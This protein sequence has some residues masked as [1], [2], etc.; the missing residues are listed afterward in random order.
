M[1]Y[2][3]RSEFNKH[4]CLSLWPRA[5]A[6]FML[7]CYSSFRDF[8]PVQPPDL[9]SLTF[10]AH[11]SQSAQQ[12]MDERKTNIAVRSYYKKK[13]ITRTQ[14]HRHYTKAHTHTL[15]DVNTAVSPSSSRENDWAAWWWHNIKWAANPRLRWMTE[16]VFIT[17]H[18]YCDYKDAAFK[19]LLN[20]P[21][22]QNWHSY[23]CWQVCQKLNCR[24]NFSS[25]CNR[26][27]MPNKFPFSCIQI[28]FCLA[29]LMS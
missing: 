19:Q 15:I 11:S 7:S 8:N 23:S 20:T 28:F 25:P 17:I 13:I 10:P 26:L 6:V 27:L 9:I 12:H 29:L 16:K 21:P 4:A 24:V 3:D 2:S 5:P 18:C 1:Y 22:T 14:T